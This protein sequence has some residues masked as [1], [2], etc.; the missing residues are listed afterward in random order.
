MLARMRIFSP[1]APGRALCWP[2]GHTS[3]RPAIEDE[4]PSGAN[5][6][7]GGAPGAPA[8]GRAWLTA[9][10]PAPL[11]GLVLARMRILSP[12]PPAGV[13]AGQD[14]HPQPPPPA[15]PVPARTDRTPSPYL[16][17]LFSP[18]PLTVP[19]SSNDPGRHRGDLPQRRIVEDDIRRH[20]RLLRLPRPP[21]PQRLEDRHGLGGQVDGRGPC[22]DLCALPAFGRPLR[23]RRIRTCTL[24]A[25]TSA[26]ARSAPACRTRPPPRAAPAPATAAPHR[27]IGSRRVRPRY[28]R[29]TARHGR[30]G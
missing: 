25:S 17:S 21:R 4:R 27:A 7:W 15:G 18:T 16:A 9:Q 1:P 14:R 19:N 28:R 11:A 22:A 29:P 10:F 3:A 6:V 26:L 20:P 12:P 23:L 30:A 24:P 8:A 5:G 2:T 13:D